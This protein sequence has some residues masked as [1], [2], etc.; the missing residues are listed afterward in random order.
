MWPE[1]DDRLL[2]DSRDALP[3]PDEEAQ[4][5]RIAELLARGERAAR[6]RRR[7]LALAAAAT[8]VLAASL[9]ALAADRGD[10]TPAGT[11]TA[12]IVDRT[13]ACRTQSRMPM[14]VRSFPAG[15]VIQSA[16]STTIAPTWFAVGAGPFGGPWPFAVVR[17]ARFAR[18]PE[19]GGP[20]AAGAFVDPRRC[21]PTR[22]TIPL[23]RTGLPGPP[24]EYDKVANCAGATRV[25]V[26]MRAVLAAPARWSRL[27]SD[28]TGARGG[29][30]EAAIA[31]RDD[32]GSPLAFMQ[33]RGTTSRL[34]LAGRC[35]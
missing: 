17:V 25:Y 7:P 21:V 27:T 35:S 30:S 26:R 5:R 22:R 29:V 34:W 20:P 18:A 4:R 3:R 8:I 14:K 6:R 11:A 10:R 1:L 13:F 16:T 28:Y 32:R 24:Y 2:R 12:R 9:V 33:L 23:A 31:V 19:W 15:K